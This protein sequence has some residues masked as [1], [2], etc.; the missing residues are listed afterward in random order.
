M[1]V[2]KVTKSRKSEFPNPI[3]VTKGEEVL[4]IQE[5]SQEGDW[6]GWILCQT[7]D[8]EGWVPH[9]IVSVK[10]KAGIIIEDYCAEEFDLEIGEILISKKEMNG[11]IWCHKENN[12]DKMAWAP[13]NHLE[14]LI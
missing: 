12:S 14:L 4:C 5:S 13:L 9:Q 11:W 1:K 2:Y 6:A 3:T 7:K 8:N 10:D